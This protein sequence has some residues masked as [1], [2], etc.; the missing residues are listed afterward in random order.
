[1][2]KLS[3]KMNL[4]EPMMSEIE[5][6]DT[7]GPRLQIIEHKITDAVNEIM[8][9]YPDPVGSHAEMMTKTV[10]IPFPWFIWLTGAMN[11]LT[12]RYVL[13]EGGTHGEDRPN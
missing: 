9:A 12:S 4:A 10:S 8:L 7:L 11:Y 6:L 3:I 1:M 5:Q 2:E 13:L